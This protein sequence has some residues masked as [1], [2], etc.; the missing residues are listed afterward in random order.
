VTHLETCPPSGWRR[1]FRLARVIAGVPGVNTPTANST[2][3]DRHRQASRDR[4]GL[5]RSRGELST[6]VHL[7]A[8]ARCRPLVAL[9]SPGQR[10]DTLAFAPLMAR[11]RIPR[12]GPARPRCRPDRLLGN[13]AYSSAPLRADL[14]RRGIKGT[15]PTPADQAG[16]RARRGSKGGRPPAFDPAAYRG[17]NTGV[18]HGSWTGTL[19]LRG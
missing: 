2:P 15:I 10:G 18:D 12:A 6:K 19:A 17:R 11:L 5:G 7:L 4:E 3:T 1:R 14:R 16:H 8:D 9:T 13:K